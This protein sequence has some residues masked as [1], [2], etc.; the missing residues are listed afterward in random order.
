MKNSTHHQRLAKHN[1]TFYKNLNINKNRRYTTHTQWPKRNAGSVRGIPKGSP[2]QPDR[3][4]ELKHPW[5]IIE[6]WKWNANL[7]I[8]SPKKSLHMIGWR[9]SQASTT[10]QKQRINSI[11]SSLNQNVA[12][13]TEGKRKRTSKSWHQK[14]IFQKKSKLGL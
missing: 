2:G 7:K 3:S 10:R 5:L 9:N 1:A 4:T 12:V 14:R 13:F 6:N 8:W 11:V